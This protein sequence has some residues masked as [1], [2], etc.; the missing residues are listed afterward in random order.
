MNKSTIIYQVKQQVAK[1]RFNR[2]HRLN[3]VTEVFYSE[4]LKAL[5]EA[6]DDPN[7]RS[8]ILTGEGRAFCVG[9][10]M[11]EHDAGQRTAFQRREYLRGEQR[12]CKRL[13]TLSKPV[14]AG[15]NGYAL[16]AG[17]EMAVASDFIVMSES[18]EFG[19]PEVSIGTF[20]G[21]GVSKLLPQLVG[22][23]KARELIYFG[24]RIS[25]EEAV[26]IGLASKVFPD[27][28]FTNDVNEFA[29]QLAE[30]A[31]ISMAL[32][33]EHLL[34]GLTRSVDDALNAELEGMAFCASTKDWQEGID[35]FTEK[36][37][38]LFTGK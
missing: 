37:P 27:S 12:V 25:G 19:L 17:A 15:L 21:G 28:T 35:A 36:R 30:K 16:G 24:K 38:P 14:I 18:A 10:D 4:L 20:I 13:M 23:A 29:R 32:A 2:P 3:A 6:E 8:I 33:K 31:P 9:A 22:M 5:Q 34:A 26:N 11:K 7:V 1:I